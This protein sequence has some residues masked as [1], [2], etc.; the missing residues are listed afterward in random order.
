MK[1]G[2][3]VTMP[4]AADQSIGVVVSVTPPKG[5][6]QWWYRGRRVAILW[7]DGYGEIDWEPST[8]LEVVS[9]SR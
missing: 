9:E 1:I 7:C 4:G 2:D 3:L 6:P 8:W 5:K